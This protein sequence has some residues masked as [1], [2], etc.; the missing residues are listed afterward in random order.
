MID[1]ALAAF[2]QEG[3]GI[4]LGTR[5]AS[6]EPNGVLVPAV[7]VEDDVVEMRQERRGSR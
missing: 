6:L 3:I 4:Q 7:K 1:K 2:L 5:S